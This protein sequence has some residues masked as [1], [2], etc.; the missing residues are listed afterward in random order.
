M[1][2]WMAASGCDEERFKSVLK[3]IAFMPEIM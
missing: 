2:A 3:V 1:V